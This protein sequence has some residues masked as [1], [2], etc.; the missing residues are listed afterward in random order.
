[1]NDV[2]RDALVDAYIER[3]AKRIVLGPDNVFIEQDLNLWAEERF[4]SLTWSDPE[5]LWLLILRV[6]E[7]TDK[8][9]VLAMLAA[10]PLEVL[11]EYHGPNFIDRIEER[12]KS[13]AAFREVLWGLWPSSSSPVASRVEAARA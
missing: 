2:E 5:Q 8:P 12:A 11:I 6:L 1:M 3:Y 10:G 4:Q 9:D 13:D 7:K